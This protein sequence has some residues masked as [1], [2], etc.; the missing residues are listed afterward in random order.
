M[1]EG[2]GLQRNGHLRQYFGLG[3]GELGK[4]VEFGR[5]L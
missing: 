1:F 5:L 3:G 4:L 2:L